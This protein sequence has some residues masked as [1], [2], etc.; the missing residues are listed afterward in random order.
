MK[1]MLKKVKR[2]LAVCL[3]MGLFMTTCLTVSAQENADS[4]IM[5]E[6]LEKVAAGVEVYPLVN[7]EGV[8]VGY[9]EPNRE[10]RVNAVM[11]RYD[12]NVNWTLKSYQY[13]IGENAYTL[14]EGDKIYINIEQS[15]S[16]TSYLGIYNTS[17][18]KL[19]VFMGTKT[20]N[21]WNGT[22]TLGDVSQATYRFAIYNQSEST[23]TYTGY[24]SL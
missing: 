12:A 8:M 5:Q 22:I 9:Y 17:T 23:I 16:G 14:G 10:E 1:N 3:C 18:D 15:V 24:Y 11:P 20:T 7:E 13:G 2:C 21:G 4:D 19:T 6:Y